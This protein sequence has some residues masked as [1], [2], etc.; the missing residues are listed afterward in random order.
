[1]VY[2]KVEPTSGGLSVG[3]APSHIEAVTGKRCRP[4]GVWPNSGIVIL[5]GGEVGDIPKIQDGL[6]YR[7]THLDPPPRELVL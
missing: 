4:C 3:L 5:E 6:G 1:M 7:V 2:L